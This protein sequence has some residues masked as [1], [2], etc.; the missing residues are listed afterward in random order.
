MEAE[1]TGP[2]ET[3]HLENAP[4]RRSRSLVRMA[5]GA[6]AATACIAFLLRPGRRAPGDETGRRPV[7]AVA[8]VTRG[9]LR[10]TASFQAELRPFYSVDLHAKFP[11]FVRTLQVDI[12]SRVLK[13]AVL[14]VL[15]VPLLAEDMDRAKAALGRTREEIRRAEAAS[16]DA[17]LSSERLEAAAKS[18]PNLI[19]RQNL[20]TARAGDLEAQASLAGARQ[21]AAAAEA[22]LARL[23]T[24]DV[25]RRVTA[26]FDGVVT[27]LFANPGDSL[28]GGLSPSGEARPL[29]RLAQLDP[30]RLCFPVSISYVDRVRP[31][32]LVILLLDDGRTLTNR[33]SRVS[34]DLDM[35]TRMMEA[36]A[37]VA[38][39]DGLL[40]PGVYGRAVVS[41][42]VQ[43][44]VLLAPV[45][46][47]HR[48][49]P[50][51][52]LV[53]APDGAVRRTVVKLGME[54]PNQVE[55]LE[56]LKEGELVVIGGGARA[57]GK[58]EPKIT[59]SL[60]DL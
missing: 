4:P 36:Q 56:G 21:Q 48:D 28:Q 52:A 7:V 22:E 20:D 23:Q 51:T 25:E 3:V 14:A 27:R 15:D 46:A 54:S 9:D 38:N 30:L 45:E 58:V 34:G 53:V 5:A 40:T 42:G 13:G 57:G 6:A 44:G 12:G 16:A 18:Q 55:V 60:S 49:T 29:V 10:Q 26:P 39:P 41:I 24:Q 59:G 2:A 37:D 32:D 19:A 33:I 17:H 47:I 35:A 43:K 50:P 1:N 31:G 11:G 8:R